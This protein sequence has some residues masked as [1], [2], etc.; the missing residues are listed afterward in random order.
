ML[1][2]AVSEYYSVNLAS[3]GVANCVDVENAAACIDS[4][5]VAAKM[6]DDYFR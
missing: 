5:V 2:A 4:K 3:D 6:I 1:D